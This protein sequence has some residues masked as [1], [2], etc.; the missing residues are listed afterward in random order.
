MHRFSILIIEDKISTTA[1]ITRTIGQYL[2][3][4]TLFV[5]KDIFEAIDD[6]QNADLILSNISQIDSAKAVDSL[7]L[8][9][10]AYPHTPVL[11]LQN[12]DANQES[13]LAALTA[14]E[15]E[16]IT[17]SE[18]GL[19]LLGRRLRK[20]QQAW[21]KK[22]AS[23]DAELLLDS[24]LAAALAADSSSQLAIQIIDQDN[25][26][27]GW[28][29]T[30]R[31]LFCISQKEINGQH[32]DDLD[33]SSENVS[34]I[35]DILDQAR[36][37]GKPFSIP[38]YLL[39]TENRE[40]RWLRVHVY[41]T[42]SHP[43]ATVDKVYIVS[44]DVTD[45]K[46]AEAEN[47]QQNQELQ[48]LLETSQESSKQLEL[49][50][51]LE[52]I[53]DQAKTLLFADNCCIYFVEKDSK[54]LRPKLAVGPLAERLY[55]APL[56]LGQGLVGAGI[57]RGKVDMLNALS[58]RPQPC[59]IEPP[60]QENEHVMFAPLTALNGMIGGMVVSR[61]GRMPF[62]EADLRFFESLIQQGSSA[63]NNARLFEETHRNLNELA[64]L[65][66]ASAAISTIWNTQTV[67][68]TLI[69]QLV[70]ATNMDSG[71]IAGWDKTHNTGIIQ[72]G[73]LGD[74]PD[75]Q[76][77]TVQPGDT[78]NLNE[79]AA[80]MSALNQQRPIVFQADN[81]QLD[82]I[83]REK[84]EAKGCHSI[85]LVPLIVKGETIGWTEL[86]ETRTERTFTADDVRLARTL[87][88]QVAVA[89]ENA[90][91]LKQTR[92]TL[93]ET[94]ALYQVA[95]ALTNTQDS[96][97][98]MSTVL[99]EFLNV[100]DLKQGSVMIFDF[101][102][103]LGVV[104]VHVQDA[105]T[106]AAHTQDNWEGRQIQ[107]SGNPFYERLMRT[108]R[109]VQIEDIEVDWF[110]ARGSSFTL[111][112]TDSW[113]A[114]GACSMLIVPIQI[115]EEIVGALI[116]EDT[117]RKRIF[118]DREMSLGQMMADQLG[119]ALQNA[120][121]YEA[122]SKRREQA[123]TLRE[124]SSAVG[125]S[126]N[127]NEVLKHIMDQLGRVVQYDRAAIHLIEGDRWRIIAERGFPNPE[128]VIGQTSPVKLDMTRPESVVIH[129]RRPLVI[130]NISDTYEMFQDPL[131]KHAKSWMGIPLIA[132]DRV[133]GL[134]SIGETEPNAYQE[135]DVELTLAFA[136]QVAVALENARLYE[137]E[138][139]DLE[140][141][142]EIAHDIQ[143]TLLP[144]FVPQVP[145]L[146]ITGRSLP[147]RQ[148]G[149]D[150]FHF[151]SVGEDQLGVAIGDVSGKGIPAALYM[152]AAITAID[153]KINDG[154]APAQLLNHLNGTLYNRL[155]ENKM[156]IGLQIATF[157][158]LASPNGNDEEARG[159]LM[160]V[161]S[162]GMIAPIGAT[163]HGCRF[164][165]VS[166]F[167]VGSFAPDHPYQEDMFLLDPFTTIIFTSDGIVE[168]Q[169]EQGELF[170]FD[171]LEAAINEIIS[172]RDAETIAEH[173][174]QTAIDF[175][176][177]V[178]QGD[179]MT[180][181]VVVKT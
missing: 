50:V 141:E 48:I 152:A 101:E 67:L 109:P 148:I 157:M 6:P 153:T 71:Y 146:K 108:H 132:R 23:T 114:H 155:Q 96:H 21:R 31:N 78:I 162:G 176:G 19:V 47:W 46:E 53:A 150:F 163:E 49:D 142:L 74:L 40:S 165:P 170:G 36:V 51:T 12:A 24:S 86:Y 75:D 131:H 59:Q 7:S 122:E 106:A 16:Y 25:R 167:P 55:A 128:H 4:Y 99:Y 180:V 166:G 15:Y 52:Q 126:L 44:T 42:R 95:S 32:L 137:L 85:L 154:L 140:R 83:E 13:L 58:R 107:L 103:R 72:A 77:R 97:T 125:S 69:R 119:V 39:E 88:N 80:L 172:T 54:K 118:N 159:S 93:E 102:T 62:E 139:R 174:I 65:Y 28:N 34:R 1:A 135:E 10:T 60:Y 20:L 57:A 11:L 94:T 178:E 161:S 145:G 29:Q 138:V 26:I 87:A 56:V 100:L 81:P 45:L 17:L 173:I 90:Q 33:L 37:T 104:K 149:G 68:N 175:M 70:H 79:R 168:A 91:Y 5:A 179:D 130:E 160:T 117:R 158:P 136:N 14:G 110:P 61:K 143:E 38:Q 151:F 144:Q 133:I 124:V 22:Q 129:K 89:L 35:K 73:F 113:A 27:L 92:Q 156:N 8:L 171:R 63:I 134:I 9:A 64:I 18:A 112:S 181:V 41:P 66:E 105:Q 111:A 82:K 169:N 164:L 121:L 76:E 115:R 84:M 177:E 123:E 2:D 147:A 127:L 116:A 98:I 120:Q 3:E 43:L 30:A